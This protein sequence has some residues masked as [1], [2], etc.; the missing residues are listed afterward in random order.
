MS[1]A[2]ARS[3]STISTPSPHTE[4]PAATWCKGCQASGAVPAGSRLLTSW[5]RQLNDDEMR[6]TTTAMMN[7]IAT[8]TPRNKI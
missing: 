4:L 6:N 1:A 8:M 2:W 5:E 7:I 3:R